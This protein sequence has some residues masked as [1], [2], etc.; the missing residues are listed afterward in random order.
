MPQLGKSIS[1]SCK[2]AKRLFKMYSYKTTKTVKNQWRQEQHKNSVQLYFHHDPEEK[3]YIKNE[4][5]DEISP[6]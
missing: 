3:C 5:K 1:L 6:R 4:K 2:Y